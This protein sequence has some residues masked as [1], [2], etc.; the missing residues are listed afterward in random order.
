MRK[1][2]FNLAW[3]VW[4][5]ALSRFFSLFCERR[6][7]GSCHRLQTRP[8]ISYH[9]AALKRGKGQVATRVVDCGSRSLAAACPWHP[10]FPIIKWGSKKNP[11]L[12]G[13]RKLKVIK[14]ESS[15]VLTFNTSKALDVPTLLSCYCSASPSL[16]FPIRKH[17]WQ[18]SLTQWMWRLEAMRCIEGPHDHLLLFQVSVFLLLF[19]SISIRAL[20]VPMSQVL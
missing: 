7:W 13:Q 19:L 11:C 6:C 17:T 9:D 10:F 8:F 5:S 4:L 1:C 16:T 18:P 20:V 12:I 15:M 2:K 3:C 14:E